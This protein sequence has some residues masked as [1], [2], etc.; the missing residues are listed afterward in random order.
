MLRDSAP[1]FVAFL[2]A[3]NLP[4]PVA[5]VGPGYERNGYVDAEGDADV[6]LELL[7]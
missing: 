3:L 5:V 7:F 1:M 2:L 4:S 6:R